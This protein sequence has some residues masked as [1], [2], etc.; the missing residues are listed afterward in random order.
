MFGLKTHLA[1]KLMVYITSSVIGAL[2]ISA[3]TQYWALQ[4]M[5]EETRARN[6]DAAIENLVGLIS[7][8]LWVFNEAAAKEAANAMLRDQFISGIVVN[9]HAMLFEFRGGDLSDSEHTNPEI[10]NIIRTE[11]IDALT[12]IIPLIIKADVNNGT[13][14]NIGSLQIRSDNLLID[15]QVNELARISLT[16]SA[17]IIITLQFLFYFLARNTITNPLEKV[18]EHVQKYATNMDPNITA[19]TLSLND[20]HDE[21]GRLYTV[22]N[23]QRLDLIQRDRSLTEYRDQLEQTVSTRTSELRE[24]NATLLESLDQ[25]KRAQTELIQ[26]EKLVSL[27]TLVSG[28]AHEVNTPL[29]IAITASSHLGGELRETEKALENNKLTKSGF[30]TFLAECR[31]TEALLTNNLNRAATLIQSFKKV[32][33]DQSS[34]QERCINLHD[35]LDEIVL[36]LRPKLKQTSISVI[37]KVPGDIEIDIAP[38]ALAQIT[39]NL[40]MNSIIHGF[41]N[42]SD[43]GEIIFRGEQ[44]ENNVTFT[45]QDTGAGM[46][47]ETLKRIYDPFFTTRRSDGG[48][49]LGMNIVYN[50]VT[51]KLNGY[52]ETKSK[53]GEGLE[54]KMTINLMK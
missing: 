41:N 53:P 8:S 43:E 10:D 26:N 30:E 40:V 12:V 9:D 14:F 3:A 31:E 13:D 2:L 51:S 33:V 22:F 19:E 24:S 36:S 11:D 1:R 16:S 5:L 15:Q 18:T 17:I 52:I 4:P 45:Y 46:D 38:G 21:I 34:D 42:G 27:G 7:Q 20:R 32:A 23:K 28:I 29:G 54:I 49:G 39:T 48:S 6:V 37:N 25:L 44:T 50:L 35:Y 47:T